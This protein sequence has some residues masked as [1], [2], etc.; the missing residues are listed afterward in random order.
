MHFNNKQS[1]FSSLL[2]LLT[3]FDSL[4]D[5]FLRYGRNPLIIKYLLQAGAHIDAE[6]ANGCTALHWAA[7]QN[8]PHVI[9]VLVHEG[10]SITCD[11]DCVVIVIVLVI[12][13]VIVLVIVFLLFAFL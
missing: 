11:C 4:C 12:V 13:S 6:D 2:I 10:A 9:Q 3:Y 5:F 7:Y 1:N 8:L